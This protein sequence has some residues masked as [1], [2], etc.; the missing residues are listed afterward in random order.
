VFFVTDANNQPL[1]DPELCA[2]LQQTIITKLSA[3][4]SASP[5][6]ISI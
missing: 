6:Q 4:S 5:L 2:R 1:S 3:S